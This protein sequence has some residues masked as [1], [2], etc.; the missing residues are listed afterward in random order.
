[1][2]NRREVV[3]AAGV[4]AVSALAGREATQ[5][6]AAQDEGD[7]GAAAN[8]PET[9]RL[10]EGDAPGA[11]GT[12]EADVPTLTVYR[13]AAERA[14]GA[15]FVVCPG[16][17]YGGL[18][19]DHEGHQVA[20]WLNGLGVAA[21]IL[22]YRLGRRY[23]HPAMLHDVARAVRTVRAKSPDWKLDGG[24][25][26]VVGFSAGGHLASTAAT[27]FDDGDDK[28]ADAVDRVSSRPDVA[29]LVYPVIM[30]SGPH[31]HA[32]SRT[33]LLG[34]DP[35][36]EMVDLMSNEKRVTDKTP[37]T[38]LVHSLDDGPVPP[39]NSFEFVGA[40]RA[41]RVPCELHLFD[42][43]GHGY[44]LGGDDPA[45]SQWPKLCAAWLGGRG[46]LKGK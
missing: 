36:Q 33:N 13:P 2:L 26:G 37:P 46:F 8:K 23:Q 6:R 41:H 5:A 39:E 40:L 9:I 29:V 32:G 3:V 1:M 24:R 21:F 18:A 42:H 4:A 35:P 25:I 44:G 20:A 31:A 22:K 38:F 27:H 28:A 34:E 11:K 16:G 17:G 12:E 14:N 45:L 15:S 10:W 43:G 30:L 7:A 19:M